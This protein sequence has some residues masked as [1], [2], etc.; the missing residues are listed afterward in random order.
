MNNLR[1][2]TFYLSGP[3]D[4]CPNLGMEWRQW[5]TPKLQAYGIKVYDP[6]N[7]PVGL[8][9][10]IEGREKRLQWKENGEYDKL[11]HWMRY[12]RHVDLRLCDKS[13]AGI[14]YLDIDIFAC[15]T[16]EETFS[17]NACKKPVILMC[18]QGL[19]A[20]PDWLWGT[21]PVEMIKDSWEQVFD[22]LDL[23]DS[24]KADDLGRWIH[25]NY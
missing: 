21:L 19:K 1:G 9:E 4:R 16:L 7:K 10:E 8:P 14:V 23:V 15:G 25:F 6:L 18:K 22:Y 12:I 5:I 17:L 24:G 11:A 13:D 20:V 3:I 2:S